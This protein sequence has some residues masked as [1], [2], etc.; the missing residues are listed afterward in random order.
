MFRPNTKMTMIVVQDMLGNPMNYNIEFNYMKKTL[1]CNQ[2][3][4]E[5]KKNEKKKRKIG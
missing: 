3:L 5:I 2:R 1:N 4:V